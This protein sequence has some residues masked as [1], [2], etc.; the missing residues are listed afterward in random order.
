MPRLANKQSATV[1]FPLQHFCSV[2]LCP[3]VV[4]GRSQIPIC[5]GPSSSP[6][7]P[8]PRPYFPPRPAPPLPPRPLSLSSSSYESRPALL[9]PLFRFF[10]FFFFCFFFF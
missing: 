6:P 2:S 1:L 7:P 9:F 8:L 4:S 5:L 3:C 10:F